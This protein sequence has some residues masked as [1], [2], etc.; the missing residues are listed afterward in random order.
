LD[1]FIKIEETH[2]N[3]LETQTNLA[4]CFF[5]LGALS[6]AKTH[7]L[8]ALELA[9]QDTQILFNLGVIYS[10]LGLLDEAIQFYQRTLQI[11]P[12]DFATHN[13]LGVAF[14]AKQHA[15]FAL[16]HFQEALKIQPHNE[17]IQHTVQV[18][19]QQKQLLVSPPQYIKTLFDAYADHYEQHLLSAL[20]YKIPE[21]L[22]HAVLSIRD[23][24]PAS[25]IILDLGCGTGLCGLA[26]KNYAKKLIGVDLSEKMLAMAAQKN[27]YD[28]LIESELCEFLKDKS[29]RYDLILSGDTLVYIGELKEIFQFAH[30]AL[31]P[32]GLFAFNTEISTADHFKMN[33]SGRFLH[34][35]NYIDSLANEF[36]FKVVY[37]ETA[38]TRLQNNAPVLGHIYILER[39]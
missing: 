2:P 37:Y 16:H 6:E 39:C 20:D 17:A 21:I 15:N 7:Y 27:G 31:K 30:R 19:S 4:T 3:H 8:K 13:N 33:Q 11:N 1:I 5:K 36:N 23:L 12:E 18:L 9:P 29:D 22:K 32:K 35:K 25:Q 24:P 38:T 14:L 28:E 10:Q 26:F 34:H